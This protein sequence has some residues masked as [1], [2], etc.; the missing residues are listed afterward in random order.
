MLYKLF[1]EK[2]YDLQYHVF[3]IKIGYR[4]DPSYYP[5]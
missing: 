3:I 2:N 5:F 1:Y 4:T